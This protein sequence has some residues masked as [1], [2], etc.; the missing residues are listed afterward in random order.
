MPLA[1]FFQHILCVLSVL[2]R[3]NLAIL[4]GER[5]S[6]FCKNT[7]VNLRAQNT[8]FCPLGRSKTAL[9]LAPEWVARRNVK[10]G[11]TKSYRFLMV[12]DRF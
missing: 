4:A 11:K 8:S 12:F 7:Y 10:M 5:K 1:V 6:H 9:A 2:A 3:L